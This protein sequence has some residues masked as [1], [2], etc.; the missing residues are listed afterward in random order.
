MSATETNGASDHY[1]I[2]QRA[3]GA[4]RCP[5]SSPLVLPAL[6]DL[7]PIKRLVFV[8][9]RLPLVL[10]QG[11][12][13][14]WRVEPGSGGLVTALTPVL[15]A[16]EGLWIGWSGTSEAVELEPLLMA[17]DVRLGYTL[18]QVPLSEADV[19]GYYRGFANEIIWPLFHDVQTRCRFDP[20]YWAVYQDVNHRFAQAAADNLTEGDYVWVQDYH[21]MLVASYLREMGVE[22]PLGFFLHT[23]F[24][25][26]DI[27]IKLPWRQQILEGLMAYDLLGFQTLRDRNNFLACAE[28]LLNIDL[29]DLQQPVVSVATDERRIRAGYFSISIDFDEFDQMARTPEVVERV[30]TLREEIPDGARFLGVD[31]LDYSKGIPERLEAFQCALE[32]FPGLCGEVSLIQVVV[33]S[34]ANIPEY[35]RLRTQIEELV[36][37]IN[38]KFS[39]PGWTPI[40]YLYRSL[41]RSELVA[42][43]QTAD[44]ALITPLNPTTSF[45]IFSCI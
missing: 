14:A 36:S 4:Q 7:K 42:L 24:P 16:R 26:V 34:R 15:R 28:A 37:R 22:Q 23:P 11:E 1:A 39:Q 40:H 2:H 29:P 8:S 9:N 12:D 20:A 33:P 27:F 25:P 43:Y 18:Q 13:G 17:N 21:L 35:Q 38:G 44:A 3:S 5:S 10:Y 32:R 6:S 19:D 45:I 41:E 31:R 30:K